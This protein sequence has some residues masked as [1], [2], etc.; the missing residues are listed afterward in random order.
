MNRRGLLA[1]FGL[2]LLACGARSNDARVRG[3]WQYHEDSVIYNITFADNHAYVETM[4]HTDAPVT[5]NWR[6]EG[7]YLIITTGLKNDS[8]NLSAD[9]SEIVKLDDESMILKSPPDSLNR[10]LKTVFRVK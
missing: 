1:I 8:E 7:K 3:A 4:S 2:F 9:T 5:G 10:K 6:I